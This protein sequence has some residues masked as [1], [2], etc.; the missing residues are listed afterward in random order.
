MSD[1]CAFCDGAIKE[2]TFASTDDF[3]ALYNIAPIVPGHSL[4]VPRTHL[5]RISDLPESQFCAFWAFGH[6][7][8][9]FLLDTF[10]TNAFDWTIQ[11]QEP[12]GQT[13]PHLH[14]HVIPR[15]PKD[16]EDPGDWYPKLRSGRIVD[17]AREILDSND[18]VKLTLEERSQIAG[19]LAKKWPDWTA[20]G[21]A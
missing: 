19:E 2:S 16:F 6:E 1:S 8:T 11:E 10:K 3:V 17:H 7:V 4:V 12:A 21:S 14:L 18:R 13:V 15:V 5:R 9:R 20:S